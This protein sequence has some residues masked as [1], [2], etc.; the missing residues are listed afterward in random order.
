MSMSSRF[1]M[2]A[3]SET[4]KVVIWDGKKQVLLCNFGEAEQGGWAISK[5]QEIVVLSVQPKP[6]KILYTLHDYLSDAN[7]A[8]LASIPVPV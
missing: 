7:N 4:S 2:I 5:V 6:E 8:E 3:D 1:V